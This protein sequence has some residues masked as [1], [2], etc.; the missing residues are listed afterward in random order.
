MDQMMS[1]TTKHSVR[2]SISRSLMG[3]TLLLAASAS[4][5]HAGPFDNMLGSWSGSGTIYVSDGGQERIRCR[6]SYNVDN[7]GALNQVLRCASDS[8]RFEL[9]SNVVNSGGDLTGSWGEATR[10]ISGTLQ[11]HM[12]GGDVK[13][14]VQTAGFNANLALSTRGNKQTISIRSDN[15]DLRGVDIAL[16]K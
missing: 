9:S 11:G 7:Q 6:A 2:Q 4:Y 15:T 16:S 3:A 14:L 10:G 8:Y 12:S 1:S 13:A 5:A